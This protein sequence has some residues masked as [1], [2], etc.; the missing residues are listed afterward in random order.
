MPR[1]DVR[2]VKA[3]VKFL[4]TP[5]GI[6]LLSACFLAALPFLVSRAITSSQQQTASRQQLQRIRTELA[7]RL[8]QWTLYSRLPEVQKRFQDSFSQFAAVLLAV[9]DDKD[10]LVPMYS[11]YPEFAT[12]PLVALLTQGRALVAGNESYQFERPMWSAIV[13]TASRIADPS[14]SSLPGRVD[15]FLDYTGLRVFRPSEP[16]AAIRGSVVP[17]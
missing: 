16:S 4:N 3:I 17:Q 14:G 2:S 10:P 11:T 8:V 1:S 13:A 12:Q 9:P 5:L 7:Y 15:A 6:W